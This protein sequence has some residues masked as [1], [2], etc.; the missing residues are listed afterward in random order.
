MTL[1]NIAQAVVT[2]PVVPV[3]LVSR[4]LEGLLFATQALRFLSLHLQEANARWVI[5]ARVGTSSPLNA[6]RA[7]T[8][9]SL[10]SH[11]KPAAYPAQLASTV[12][13]SA[14][15]LRL[16]IA[17]LASSALE[18]RHCLSPQT[19]SRANFAVRASTALQAPPPSSFALMAS[20]NHVKALPRANS[21][22]LATSALK[23]V[24]TL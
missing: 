4:V 13:S 23:G 17:L 10:E 19:E 9:V 11:P 2:P 18:D 6:R 15:S 1:A 7:A 20:T 21:A 8:T 12:T 3:M 14:S 22:L 5:T 24:L 16:K